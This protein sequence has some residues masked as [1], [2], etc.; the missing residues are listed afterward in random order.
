MD[1]PRSCWVVLDHRH[2]PNQLAE[3][4]GWY[5]VK[6]AENQASYIRNQRDCIYEAIQVVEITLQ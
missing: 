6:D 5:D 2:E 1:K 3:L 4:A